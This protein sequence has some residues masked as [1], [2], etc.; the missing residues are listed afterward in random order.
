MLR[1]GLTIAAV[2]APNTS[3]M[4]PSSAASATSDMLDLALGDVPAL[5]AQSLTGKSQDRV[6]GDTLQNGTVKRSSDK[7]L[8]AGLLVL[9]GNE[10][11][12]SADLGHVLLLAEEP[13]VLLEATGGSLE[14]G[15]NAG[16][17]VGTKLLVT[18]TAGPGTDGVVSGLQGDGLEASGVVRAQ[19]DWQ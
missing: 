5:R 4:R 15:Q 2:P 11:V 1:T 6:A 18:N 8:L 16:S 9:H 3:I 13:Q 19:R 10:E 14:L 12:H 7:L 17:I